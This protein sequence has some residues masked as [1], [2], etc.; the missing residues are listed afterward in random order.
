VIDVVREEATEDAQRIGGVAP[1]QETYLKTP[2]LVL[3]W[4]RGIWLVVLFFAAFTTALILDGYE[5]HARNY[6]WLIAFIPLIASTGV[7]SGNQSA[8]LIITALA[9]G[10]V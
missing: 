1:L 2:L 4:K 8:T 9:A 6:S 7:N 5:E 10:D 3:S